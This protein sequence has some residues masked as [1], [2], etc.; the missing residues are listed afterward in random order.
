MFIHL[1]KYRLKSF[2]KPSQELFWSLAF[3][4][5]LCTFFY[6]GFGSIMNGT[7]TFKAIKVALVEEK[8]ADQYFS[9][10]LEE[11]SKEGDNQLIELSKLSKDD[12]MEQLQNEDIFGVIFVND[13]ISLTVNGQGYEQSLLKTVLDQYKH[14]AT[15]I[16][17]LAKTNPEAITNVLSSLGTSLRAN[18]EITLSKHNN[19]DPMTSY[20]FALIAMQCLYSCLLGFRATVT[21]QANLSDLAARR[22]VSPSNK[23]AVIFSDFLGSLLVQYAGICLLI[24]Y[25]NFILGISFG[26]RLPFVFLT[27]FVGCIVGISLGI[28]IT[29]ILKCRISLKLSILISGTLILCFCSGLMYN[30]MQFIIEKNLPFLNRIN[31]AVLISDSLLS[32]SIYDDYSHYLFNMA[33]L[34][35]MAILLCFGSFFATRREKYASI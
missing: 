35:V 16:S 9:S 30:G 32:L 23:L 20:F 7:D 34:T 12:A 27:S 6:L 4:F 25:I 2:L 10:F 28:F 18:E 14:T 15:T 13:D 17:N 24:C 1:L 21:S 8:P 3:P 19:T 11:I 29:S 5:I 22:C 31:P 33:I 26:D